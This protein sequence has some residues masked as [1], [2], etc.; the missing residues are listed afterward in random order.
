MGEEGGAQIAEEGLAVGG[1]AGEVAVF[2]FG[3]CHFGGKKQ[4]REEREGRR[5]VRVVGVCGMGG[6]VE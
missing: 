6:E 1:G 3:A 5:C 4:R 2:R